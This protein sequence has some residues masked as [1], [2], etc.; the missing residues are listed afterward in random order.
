[1]P[2][3]VSWGQYLKFTACALLSMAAGSQMVH[4]YYRPLDD[5]DLYIEKM[6]KELKKTWSIE[7]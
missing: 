6:E 2:A 7:E 3:G 4:L 1:M 5:M